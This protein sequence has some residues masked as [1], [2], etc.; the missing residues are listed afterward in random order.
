[1]TK[2]GHDNGWRMLRI[3]VIEWINKAKTLRIE[4]KPDP[5]GE[6]KSIPLINMTHPSLEEALYKMNP[7]VT[8]PIE[9]LD[10]HEESTMELEK[11]GYINEH[12]SYIMIISLNPCSH[13]KSPELIDLSTTTYE[14]FNPLMLL[15]HKNFERVVVDAFVYHK[16][17]RSYLCWHK[18]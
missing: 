6:L 16:Y 4:P 8:N 2:K 9:I 10:I 13:G 14:I 15:V 7:R 5:K 17:C 18:S 3:H 11:E 12:G 1:M